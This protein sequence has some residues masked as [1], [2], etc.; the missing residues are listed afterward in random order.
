V[1]ETTL[2]CRLSDGYCDCC[3]LLVDLDG[4][5][6]TAVERED[7]GGGALPVTVESP[8]TPVR[9]HGCGVLAVGHGRVD[10]GL[11]DVP[12]GDRPVRIRWRK[13][14]WRCLER[15]CSVGSFVERDAAIARPRGLLTARACRW[16]IGQLRREHESVAGLARQ[17]GTTWNTV[18]KAFRPCCRPQP[19]TSHGS[20][21]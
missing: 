16:A 4:L 7:G 2:C 15:A 18:W 6:V 1:P 19:T 17:L 5:L 3:D 12:S 11:V 20:R 9:C 21:A 13:R 14:R 8:R 10:M